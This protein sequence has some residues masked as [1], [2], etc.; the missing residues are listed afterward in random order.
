MIHSKYTIPGAVVYCK[1]AHAH[2][3]THRH[4]GAGGEALPP[5]TQTYIPQAQRLQA[6]LAR[7]VSLLVSDLR[8]LQAAAVAPGA[9]GASEEDVAVA[10]ERARA[11]SVNV[12][13]AFAMFQQLW[14]DLNAGLDAV[15]Q[16]EDEI[17]SLLL[18]VGP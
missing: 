17:Q 13:Q 7:H 9:V 6:N 11:E 5:D 4:T 14:A 8:V 16:L 1:P 15:Q 3:H 10:Q 2:A 12:A 18:Q